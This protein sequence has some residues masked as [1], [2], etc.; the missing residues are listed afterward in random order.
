MFVV[1]FCLTRDKRSVAEGGVRRLCRGLDAIARS[2]R[3]YTAR[4]RCE[5]ERGIRCDLHPASP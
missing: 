5:D 1:A 2:S 3:N 4:S